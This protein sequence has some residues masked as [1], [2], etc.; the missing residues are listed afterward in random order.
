MFPRVTQ[1]A[2]ERLNIKVSSKF[3][4]LIITAFEKNNGKK[5]MLREKGASSI[6][7][8]YTNQDTS[9]EYDFTLHHTIPTF[10]TPEENAF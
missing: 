10:K 5:P 2:I 4:S 6:F 7:M 9:Q 1:G 8:H 3:Q